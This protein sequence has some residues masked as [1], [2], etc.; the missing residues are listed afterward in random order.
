MFDQCTRD[1]RLKIVKSLKLNSSGVDGLS[2]RAFKAIMHYIL[3][4][5]LFIINL[6]LE[7]G[8]FPDQLK[9]AK[10]IPLHKG[11]PKKEIENWRPISILPLLSNLLEKV[12]HN[13]LYG[14]LQAN[15]LLSETQFGFRNGHSTTNA[16]QHLVESSNSGIDRGKH[17]CLYLLIFAKRSIQLIF[18]R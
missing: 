16:L 7:K 18:K 12:V 15:S 6:T 10:V 3:P 11:G 1:E 17:H 14:F 4:P 8:C 2:L 9:A 13:R 5:L